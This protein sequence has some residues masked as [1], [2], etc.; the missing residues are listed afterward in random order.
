M[1]DNTKEK[2]KVT[3]NQK[4]MLGLLTA[5]IILG[6][7]GGGIYWYATKD[8]ISIDK[9]EITATKIFLASKTGGTLDEIMVK[10]G[11]RIG[12]NYPVARLGSQLITSD[13]GGIVVDV[14]DNIGKNFNPGE[15]IVTMIYPE[16]LRV[17]GHIDENK[18]LKDIQVGQKAIFTV[19]AFD[20]KQ[21]TGIVDEISQVSNDTSL[22]FSISD[23][24]AVKQ[25][26]IKVRFNISQYPEFKD[27]M[28]A[29]L[30]I[31]KK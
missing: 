19:D 17:V 27:G 5:V 25:Y 2:K 9:S 10:P 26:D 14:N 11:D 3:T 15:A 16:E 21:Y 4:L 13:R 30:S 18:G 24:R 8:R 31:Y 28:S 29:K 7:L 1:E 20:S 6:A 12:E 23:K 22:V